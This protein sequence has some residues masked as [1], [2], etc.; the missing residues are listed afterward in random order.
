MNL[1]IDLHVHS[2]LSP[3]GIDSL[4]SLLDAARGRG[5]DAIALTDHDIPSTALSG[6][7]LVI[8]G[9]EI[10]TSDGHIL[11]LFTSGGEYTLRSRL[12]RLP[13]AREAIEEIHA[14][15]GVA[16]WAHPYERREEVSADAA[17][18]DLIETQNA[19][20]DFK[21]FHANAKARDLARRLQKPASGGSD[22]HSRHEVGNALTVADCA[23]R[24]LE[25][26][27]AALLAGRTRP[28]L[29][30]STPRLRKAL[31]QLKKCRRTHASP[32]RLL[33]AVLYFP[34]CLLLDVKSLF[35]KREK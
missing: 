31:S 3:D 33:K 32:A 10:S 18:A 30:R 19:R 5:L 25:D 35:A 9:I 8:P 17:L 26:I 29:I 21:R 7:V 4:E 20:A 13:T 1:K 16:V 23:G 27:K 12:G 24:T 15:G 2:D 11:G 6:D 14:R 22:A 28:Q 34:Y